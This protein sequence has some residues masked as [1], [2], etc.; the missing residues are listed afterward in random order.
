MKLHVSMLEI[1]KSVGTYLGIPF[2]AGF[3]TRYILRPRMGADWYDRKFLPKIS[4]IT[5]AALLFTIAVMF[6]LKGNQMIALPVDTLRI[7]LPMTIYFIVMFFFSF[8]LSEKAGATYAQAASLS[9]TAASNNFELAIAVA[10]STFG[11][12]HGASFATVIGP[13][14]E[15]PLLISL[16]S[17]A[18]WFRNRFFIRGAN[19][20][21]IP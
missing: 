17:V 9:F 7:A 16:V 14:V 5:L 11:I 18:F 6:S 3:L 21:V 19:A 20:R 1:A 2:G 8:V 15:V 4:P 10:I 13:L 12:N